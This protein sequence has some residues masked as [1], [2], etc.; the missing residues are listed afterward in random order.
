MRTNDAPAPQRSN[1]ARHPGILCDWVANPHDYKARSLLIFFRITQKLM[2]DL[3]SPRRVAYPLI[4]LYRIYSEWILKVELRPKTEVGKALSLYHGFG[5]VIN[6][7]SVIGSHVQLRHGVTIGHKA[8]GGACPV[9]GDY[10]EFG[11]HAVVI[12]DCTVG[13]HSKIGAGVVL[14][15]SVP[16]HSIVRNSRPQ[17]VARRRCDTEFSQ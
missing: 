14:S 13:A 2:G 8:A 10:V 3:R 17:V 1:S 11:A 15:N 16:E 6:N 7:Q 12:G 9:I 5:I 4:F